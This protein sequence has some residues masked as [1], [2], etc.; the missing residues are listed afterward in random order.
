MYGSAAQ[1]KKH[2]HNLPLAI[3]AMH[4][5]K[6]F[7]DCDLPP[8]SDCDVPRIF[9]PDSPESDSNLH[10]RYTGK[11]DHVRWPHTHYHLQHSWSL[12]VFRQ[13]GSN[14]PHRCIERC[15]DLYSHPIHDY[16]LNSPHPF[17]KKKKRYHQR[18]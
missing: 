13:Y 10:D 11:S 15:F 18:I 1:F 8:K 6:K 4:H 5:T 3:D 9:A 17:I 12:P 2:V 16:H 7:A 14:P